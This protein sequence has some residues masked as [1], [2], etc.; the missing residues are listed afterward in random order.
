VSNRDRQVADS[1]IRLCLDCGKCTVVCPVAQSDPEFNPRLIAQRR[2]AQNSGKLDDTIWSCLS[3]YM[4]VERC[5]YRVDF[6]EFIHQLRAEALDEGASL[7]CS[8]GGALQALMHLMSRDDLRQDRL[9]W[10]PEDIELSED[11]D[12]I[13][14]VGCAPYFDVVFS[15]LEVNTLAGVRGALRLL[16]RAGIPFKL[17]ANERCCGRDLLV[18]GDTEGFL[19]LARANIEEFRR[20]GVKKIITNCPEG[21]NTLKDD[22]PRAL[23]D[24]GIEVKHLTEVVA[25]LLQNGELTLGSAE[26]R[27]TYHDPCTLGRCSRIF[28]EP[29]EILQAI[30]GL[31]LV[32]MEQNREKSLCCGASPWV[33]CGAVNRQIQEQRL[34]QAEA[35]EAEVMVTA[36][37]K[38]QIH[39][40]CAQRS[41]NGKAPQ[42]DIQDLA[43]L[44]AR[45]LGLGGESVD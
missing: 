35:V 18:Q 40:K 19:A 34:A 42:V 5:N 44:A 4:C 15:D 27:A 38:C 8:H 22:Y 37:P 39:L 7:H 9:D 30:E 26:K 33:R 45:S 16:N 21:H 6:P 41:G 13:F 17:L 2:L 14:F 3:C 24:T 12:T 1:R 29:R 20:H 25:P 31:D 10:L 11:S 23:G 32:E 28:D 43:S 36:C